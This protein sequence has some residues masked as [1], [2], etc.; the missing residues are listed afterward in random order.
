VLLGLPAGK[1]SCPLIALK[2]ASAELKAATKKVLDSVK[3]HPDGAAAR[4]LIAE[5]T[6][7]PSSLGFWL[8]VHMDVHLSPK[9]QLALA[10]V[11]GV[12]LG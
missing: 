10:Q 7:R 5:L 1:P 3:A 9:A 12:R 4:V 8:M 6:H 11:A 2:H